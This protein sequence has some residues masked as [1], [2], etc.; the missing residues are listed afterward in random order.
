M[1]RLTI[2][3]AVMGLALTAAAAVQPI[4]QRFVQEIAH[5]HTRTN[6]LPP[7]AVQLVEVTPDGAPRIFAQSRWWTYRQD[8]WEPLAEIPESGA[9]EFRFPD[10]GGRPQ[11]AGLPHAEI[12]QVLRHGAR[13]YLISARE[14]FAWEDGSLRK[15][16]WPSGR[17]IRQAALAP[18]GSLWVASSGGLYSLVGGGWNPVWVAGIQGRVWEPEDVLGVAF[19]SK[20]RPWFATRAR[21]GVE[22]DG[23]WTFFEGRDGLP[24]NDF[25]S[26]SA[27]ADG[28]VWFG[29]RLGAIRFDGREW[30]YRQGPRWLP[31]DEVRQIAVNA[32]GDAWMATADGVGWIERRPFTLAEKAVVYEREI[33]QHIRRTPFGYV[34]VAPLK[35]PGDRASANPDDDDNDGLW[36]AMYG[37]GECFAWAATRDPA[38]RERARKAFEA[39]KFLQDVTQGGTPAPPDGYVARTIRSVDLPDPNVGRIEGDRRMKAERDTMWKVYEPRWPKSADGKWYWK[40]D[41][42]SDELD[43]HYFLY[44]QYFE[45]CADTPAEKA[46]VADVVRRLTDHL[47]SHQYTLVDVDGTPTRWGV[48]GPEALNR[49]PRWW[50]ERGLNS[51]SLLSYLAVAEH[52]TGDAKYGRASRELIDRHGYAQNAMV[53]K[54]QAGIGSGNQSDDE[55]AFMCFYNLIRYSRDAEL[56]QRMRLSFLNLWSLEEPEMNAFFNFAFAAVNLGESI[57]TQWGATDLSPWGDWLDAS[58]AMLTGL[59]LDRISW[60]ARN[61][62]RLDLQ[63]LPRQNSIDVME[64]DRRARGWRVNQKVLPV[65]NRDFHHWN[66]DPWTL[67]YGGNGES[68]GSGTVFLLPYYLGLYH[69]FVEKP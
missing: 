16:A 19:D 4:P 65:E 5:H 2:L 47:M 41:T 50:W 44:A 11:S 23:K 68:L 61:S 49:D 3:A 9:G 39:L 33:D 22:D 67:D 55:M 26:V 1:L 18:D 14:P 40:S 64:P 60:S 38:A 53:P 45:L 32:R 43:G 58:R 7:G 21:V 69:G 27:G 42:S 46:R 24:W 54:I 62:H 34:A 13:S 31:S 28:S 52:V 17:T 51:L 20:G 8:R 48:Y 37:A 35:V 63:R 6:R 57:T 56:R 15:L 36:T 29:T 10:A 25:T 59:P 66:T 12:L 30:H